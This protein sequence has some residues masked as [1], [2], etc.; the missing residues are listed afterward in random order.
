MTPLLHRIHHPRRFRRLM[1]MLAAMLMMLV[2][3]SGHADPTI[4]LTSHTDKVLL[5][6]D[7][8]FLEDPGGQYQIEDIINGRWDDRFFTSNKER[9]SFGFKGD[10]Y[11]QHARLVYSARGGEKV[12]E[13]MVQADYPPLDQIDVYIRRAAGDLK[14]LELGDHRPFENNVAASPFATFSI[15]TV[16][17]QPVDLYIRVKTDS[18]RQLGFVLYSSIGFSEA[19]QFQGLLSGVFYGIMLIMVFYN[20]FIFISIRDRAYLYYVLGILSFLA[21]QAALDGLPWRYQLYEDPVWYDRD[22]PIMMNVTWIW[23]MQFSRHF[24]QTRITAP[25]L[26]KVMRFMA[27]AAFWAAGLSFLVDYTISIGVAIRATILYAFALGLIGIFMWRAGN[28]LARYYT[29]AWLLYMS[30]VLLYIS[31]AFGATSHNFIVENGIRLGAFSN[32]LLLSLALADRIN[33][34]KRETEKARRRALLAKQEAQNASEQAQEHLR[35]FRQLYDNA[36]EGI[37]QC[38]LDGR[39]L[40]ANPSLAQTFG[41][42]SPSELVESV[43][44]IATDC[45]ANPE[46]RFLFE[47]ELMERR[48]VVEWE[49]L[50]LRKDGSKFWGTSSAYLA[51]DAEGRPAYLEGS[52]ID[53]TERKEKEKAQREREAAQASAQAKSDFL[54]NMSHEIRT[55]MNAIIGFAEL[56]QRTDLGSKQR[57]YVEKIEHASRTLLGIINDILD[58]SKIEAGKLDLERTEFNLHDVVNDLMDMLAHKTA[59]KNLELSVRLAKGTPTALVGDPLRLGQI[60]VNL[61]NNA[62]KFTEEGEIQLRISQQQTLDGRGCLHFSVIDTGIGISAEQLDNLF[63]PFTQADGST[64]RKFGGTGLG[65]SISKQLVELMDGEIWGESREGHGSI[66]QFTAWF[67][68]QADFEDKNIYASKELKDLRVLLLDD[69][70]AGQEALMEILTSFECQPTLMQPDYRLLERLR[71]DADAAKYDLVMIDRHLAAMRTIDAALIVRQVEALAEVPLVVMTLPNEDHL[72]DEATSC[73]FYP[74]VKPVTP[75]VILDSIQEIFGYTGPRS[76]RRFSVDEQ[77][78]IHQIL[79]GRE[80]LLVEDTAFNQEIA[81]EFLRQVDVNVTVAENGAEAVNFLEKQSF[82]AV[83]MD[84]QMPVMDGF[85]ATRRIRQQLRLSDLPIIAM[86][87]NAMKGD[88]EKCINA[89]MNDYLSKPVGQDSLYRMLADWIAGRANTLIHVG[90]PEPEAEKSH[91]EE[92]TL[93]AERPTKETGFDR[94]KALAQVSGNEKLLDDLIEHYRKDQ[95]SVIDDILDA[96]DDDNREEAHRLAHTLKGVSATLGA[97]VLSERA[98]AVEEALAS[99]AIMTQVERL[100]CHLDVAHQQLMSTFE[101]IHEESL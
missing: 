13:W 86:T 100:M 101:S 48:R 69:R 40:S 12:R 55:P 24:L 88:R 89:G 59:E 38:S 16:S 64:T 68:L 97:E 7:A 3:T 90:E 74:L 47:R 62:I 95:A 92:G 18:S 14:K 63:T 35:R 58:F 31:Y 22:L 17:D 34:Q 98:E 71:S 56:V 61:T 32:V 75:S 87:A 33:M 9:A 49:A 15:K 21:A 43:E 77:P 67:D 57:G 96:L 4:R 60:L 41:Y 99:G 94:E 76:S 73:G 39:F 51:Y 84:C 91:P 19:M 2:A 66:F 28:R 83:L 52:L 30:G 23:L 82:D 42:D 25:F 53:I 26:D 5:S 79:N 27:I 10:I 44:N 70:D 54:A 46:D 29:M 11:W 1:I 36:A 65:L 85:E 45:Y 78:D 81:R 93:L 6:A 37:F 50:F 8:R 72:M 80:V 20:L